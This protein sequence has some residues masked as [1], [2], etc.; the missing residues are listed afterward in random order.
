MLAILTLAL[1]ILPELSLALQNLPGE[2]DIEEF[3]K[4]EKNITASDAP[5]RKCEDDHKLLATL[6]GKKEMT[7]EVALK[8]FQD[9]DA[10]CDDDLGFG[11]LSQ[12]CPVT[13]GLCEE[14]EERRAVV[15]AL[16]MIRAA[17]SALTPDEQS[18]VMAGLWEDAELKNMT[19]QLREKGEQ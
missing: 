5:A 2:P 17:L 3:L 14:T 12:P 8:M 9:Q 16:Q 10:S 6:T 19:P 1:T 18:Q 11:Q 15:V 13:C 4:K 7:C